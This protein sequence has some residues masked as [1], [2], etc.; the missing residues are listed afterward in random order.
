MT[1]TVVVDESDIKTLDDQLWRRLGITQT[2]EQ[3]LVKAVATHPGEM[4]A[5]RDFA[6]QSLQGGAAKFWEMSFPKLVK[7]LTKRQI[8]ASSDGQVALS[9]DFGDRLSKLIEGQRAGDSRVA[10]TP[11]VTLEDVLAQ[12]KAREER[13]KAIEK[14]KKKTT[15][16]T[17]TKKSAGSAT[18]KK[19]AGDSSEAK[20][21]P[22]KAAAAKVVPTVA[23]EPAVTQIPAKDLFNSRR[24]NRLLDALDNNQLSL[25]QLGSRLGLSGH[26]LK[27]FIDTTSALNLTRQQENLV[28]LHW[29]GRELA[30]TTDI[31]R[32]RAV[33]DTVKKL[34]ESAEENE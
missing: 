25:D 18:P 22:A 5:V 6:G 9:D 31:D 30:R 3:L 17:A 11:G 27:R 19:R 33:M 13:L 20:A 14:E 15:R 12:A 2:F 24:V 23:E 16:K 21:T 28:E 29:D 8:L 34:R 26:S 10:P 1:A 4:T 7:D 32:R